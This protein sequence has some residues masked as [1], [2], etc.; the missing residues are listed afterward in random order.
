[1]KPLCDWQ[2]ADVLPHGAVLR[3]GGRHAFKVEF[4]GPALARVT[5][6]KDGAYRQGRSWSVAPDGDVPWTG[7][8]RD[9]VA[10]F[11]LPDVT[12][13]EDDGT[14]IL[15]TDTLRV[16][17]QTPLTLTWQ[18]RMGDDWVQ[19][20]AD[21][22]T[23][24]YLL[25]TAD[26][27]HAH[28]MARHPDDRFYGLGEKSG[29]L[30]RSGRRFE[31]RN[32]DALGYNAETTDPLYKHIPFTLTTRPGAGTLGLFYD[33]MA[34][35][36]FDLGNELD[37]YHAPYRAFRAEDGDLQFYLHWAPDMAEVVRAQHRLIGGM[38]FMPRWGLGYSGSTMA[39]TDAPD[40]QDQM[41]GFLDQIAAHDI[42]CDSFQMSSGYTSINGKRY[43]FNW[44]T[45]KFPNFPALAAQFDQAGVRLVA[46]IK[47]V[48]LTDHPRYAEAEPLFIRDSET[49]KAEVSPFWDDNGSHLDFTNPD[50]IRWW[51]DNVRTQLLD[52]GVT[53]TWNDNNE[54][55]VWDHNAQCAGFGQALPAGLIRP[56]HG[57]LMTRASYDAQRGFAPGKRPYLIS[58]CAM[59]GTQRYAQTWTGDNRTS[60]HTLR[61][62][63]PMG[64]GLSLSGFYNIGHD[65]GGFAGDKPG[66]EL[67]LRWVQ[68]GIFH[69]RFTIHSW[70]DDGTANEPWMH[71][72][73]IDL[74]RDAMALRVQLMPYFYTQ[75]WLAH[76][77]DQPMLRPLVME[78][79][80]DPKATNAQFE[81]MF[82][83]DLLVASVIE[84]LAVERVLYLPDCPEGWWDFETGTWLA[85]GQTVQR[86]VDLASIP[87]YVRG[88]AVVPMA[89]GDLALFP[90]PDGCV[91]RSSDLYED[92]GETENG[93][94][95]ETSFIL[96]S[97]DNAVALDWAQSG[98]YQ[99]AWARITPR[100]PASE[101][102]TLFIDGNPILPGT[103]I[104]FA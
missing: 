10:G 54:F 92:D 102:R 41:A 4:L 58:R 88:G 42:P 63:I 66:P 52:K 75:L 51:Q 94:A 95:R 90:A 25:G 62:N 93:P 19:I 65:V 3:V 68:N 14:L 22:P 98:A 69:P 36:W 38:G 47:P 20:A 76:T 33:T 23:G 59:P 7:R 74:V 89:N 56:L 5:L 44:N 78:F 85:G 24:A 32:L 6:T 67:F 86:P 8:S 26:H 12:L 45:D 29:P 91:A 64:L 82:G 77:T 2:L 80:D 48:L 83:P 101:S 34:T 55:E 9:A 57:H 72:E 79:P 18:A 61:W 1:M 103:A 100:L 104:P 60:W 17:V 43:V 37:N 15:Q 73:V 96:R 21:R 87:L 70:N 97:A 71:A 28:F 27:K 40:A 81:F 50:T 31:M 39:Y 49:G 16:T 84:P 99:N 11:N 46:N 53:A 13:R 35:C 30:D